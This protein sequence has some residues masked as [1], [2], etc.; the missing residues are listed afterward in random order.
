M[1]RLACIVSVEPKLLVVGESAKIAFSTAV[2]LKA[3][4]CWI[5]LR[6]SLKGPTLES[7][8]RETISFG[9][10]SMESLARPIALTPTR[11]GVYVVGPAEVAL[12]DAFG[13]ERVVKEFGEPAVAL[14]Y[15][16]PLPC[17]LTF[18]P[19]ADGYGERLRLR[20]TARAGR[21]LAGSRPYTRGDSPRSIHWRLTGHTGSLMTKQLEATAEPRIWVVL[22]ASDDKAPEARGRD[23]EL[24]TS[25][26]QSLLIDAFEVGL[27]VEGV[28]HTLVRHHDLEQGRGT[29]VVRPQRK[30]G[31]FGALVTGIVATAPT[32]RSLEPDLG[33]LGYFQRGDIALVLGPKFSTPWVSYLDSLRQR[34]VVVSWLDANFGND[35]HTIEVDHMPKGLSRGVIVKGHQGFVIEF[36]R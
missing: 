2:A 24:A 34:G 26:C 12:A 25:L 31:H 7:V 5:R 29:V 17:S 18:P 3:P 36:T 20:R 16:N 35:P 9:T 32:G 14:A 22:R 19:P 8:L 6:L 27:I 30:T 28:L 33:T 11:V 1:G 4:G 21:L 23:L 15:P 10:I 13:L